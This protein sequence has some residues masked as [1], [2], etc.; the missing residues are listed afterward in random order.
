[1]APVPSPA[2]ALRALS[3]VV[4]ASTV[5]APAAH[6][7]RLVDY[8][9]TNYPSVLFPARQ[10]YFRTIFTPLG[11]DIVV[12]QEFRSQ[13]GVD[14][15]RTN[16]LNVIEPGQWASAPFF[17][18]GDTDNALFYKPAKVQVLG[19]WAFYPNLNYQLRYVTV[20][21][22]KPVGYASDQAEFRI[23]GQHLKASQGSACTS[24][25]PNLPCETD[26]LNE[27][28]GIRDSM[29][30]MPA[31]THAIVL[32]DWNFYNSSSEPGYAKLQEI[33]VNNVGRVYDPLN[34][35]NATQNWHN[36]AAFVTIHTQC[37]CVTCPTGS[38]FSGG[39]LDDRFDQI[40]PT[41]NFGTGQGLSVVPG[42]Y[43][44]IGQ[45][46]LHFNLNITD[47]PTIPEGSTYANALW[48]ASDHLP[49]RVDLQMPAQIGGVA[50]LAFGSAIVG[51]SVSL[52]VSV[53]DTAHAP[54]DSLRFSLTTD[55][56]FVA[57]AGPFAVEA[58][59]SASPLVA[60]D[61]T[62]AGVKSG[63]LHVA[64]N[65]PDHANTDVALSGT[66][67][68]HAVASLD[69]G[70]V[71]TA[72]SIDFGALA[73]GTFTAHTVRVHDQGYGPL[74]ARLAV[75]AATVSGGDGR[76]SIAGGFTP[77]LIAGVGQSWDVQFNDA[78]ATADSEYTA[79]LTLTSGD[80]ALPGA[81][82][83]P[84]L[85]V[86]LKA[87]VASGNV[88]VGGPQLPQFTRLYAPY[89]NPTNGATLVGF[90]LALATRARLDVYDLA[91]RRV[92][93][94]AEGVMQPGR[95]SFR[96]SG[97]SDDGGA[98]GAGLYFVRLHGAGL[99]TQTARLALLK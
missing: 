93:T 56:G 36:N 42:T 9:V 40:L 70:S 65:D 47:P 23:Y 25:F 35:T 51:A 64:S 73:A 48:N 10:P 44:V 59:G 46:G 82:A 95:Y 67:L 53:A 60:L 78:G 75:A 34:P 84:D 5:L 30:A 79:T 68:A 45:D 54:A 14:S 80:E 81:L 7:L 69:S 97:R 4:L 92:A 33:Q 55:P 71:V 96:W 87:Q 15:F 98:L 58:G 86:T 16:V 17:D 1:M 99:P 24:T 77:A 2:R 21:R 22:L 57:P 19:A 43:K 83:Q 38:G 41:L 18:G 63:L 27:C 50:P 89:P 66:V 85:V 49:S 88:G 39:G 28:I 76:F 13:A 32:G 29:N 20:W 91:G 26:R 11:A 12:C 62:S 90:D 72:D 3:F 6:A 74:Q 94:L 37:P 61:A 8:N 52:A 31:G